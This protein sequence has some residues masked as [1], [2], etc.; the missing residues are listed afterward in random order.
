MPSHGPTVYLHIGLPK[1]GTTHLQSLAWRN[2]KKLKEAGV[3]YPGRMA[4]HFL[5]SND[6]RGR[7]FVGDPTTLRP[8]SWDAISSK[9]RSAPDRALVSHETLGWARTE[10][11]KRAMDSLA[12]ATVHLIVTVRDLARQV[13]AV[14]QERLKNGS[15]E[16]YSTFLKAISSRPDIKSHR[17]FWHSQDVVETLSRWSIPPPERVHVITVPPSG[18]SP[19]LLWERFASVLGVDPGVATSPAPRNN[20]SLGVAE[21]ELLRRMN[22]IL[23]EGAGS[24]SAYSRVVKGHFVGNILAGS[25]EDDRIGIPPEYRD[26]VV[27]RGQEMIDG[28]ARGG[29]DIVG[30]LAELKSTFPDTEFAAPGDV[31][32]A[33]LLKVAAE[34]VAAQAMETDRLRGQ[35]KTR[36]KSHSRR[37]PEARPH[38]GAPVPARPTPAARAEILA[39]KARRLAAKARTRAGRV[40]RRLALRTRLRQLNAVLRRR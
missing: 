27:E 32:Q 23:R 7:A 35:A 24:Q 13:P 34:C 39:A 33:R 17:R 20:T 2:Q 19:D 36:G 1:T 18:S 26:W 37:M 4:L 21:A 38:P 25:D 12:P 10:D 16:T 15:T 5:A 31:T 28:L 6:L 30:D 11:A 3:V 40:R 22:P 29:F 9:A 14:W 8:G